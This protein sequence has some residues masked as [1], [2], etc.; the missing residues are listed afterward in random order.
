VAKQYEAEATR[1]SA[2]ML[3]A[4]AIITSSMDQLQRC[5]ESSPLS[6]ET[7]IFCMHSCRISIR[8]RLLHERYCLR[9]ALSARITPIRS[10]SRARRFVAALICA[11]T[12]IPTPLLQSRGLRC[13][14][15]DPRNLGL[16]SL[17]LK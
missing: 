4:A 16:F 2:P 9:T 5:D 10:F 1:S 14:Y 7:A 6:A 8:Q 17:L 3:V 15:E 11:G 12:L 13:N